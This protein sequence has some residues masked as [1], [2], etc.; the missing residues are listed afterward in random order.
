MDLELTRVRESPRVS[1][2]SRATGEQVGYFFFRGL[3]ILYPCLLLWSNIYPVRIGGITFQLILAISMVVLATGASF[4]KVLGKMG[5][6]WIVIIAVGTIALA[7]GNTL[8]AE[9]RITLATLNVVL[10]A[11]VM[12]P[13]YGALCLAYL[14]NAKRKQQTNKLVLIVVSVSAIFGIVHFWFFPN[15]VLMNEDLHD[16]LSFEN[17]GLLGYFRESGFMGNP[18]GW[19]AFLLA[20]MIAL[21]Y[22]DLLK[23]R[24]MLGILVAL[25]LAYSIS[26]SASR[27][28]TGFALLLLAIAVRR[29]LGHLIALHSPIEILLIFFIFIVLFGGAA[30]VRIDPFTP[31]FY[32]PSRVVNDE[33]VENRIASSELGVRALLVDPMEFLLGLPLDL[34]NERL[35]D[36]GGLT[37][38]DNSFVLIAIRYG[39]PA[40]LGW[41]IGV[42]AS[43][44]KLKESRRDIIPLC[45]VGAT[46]LLN[47][48]V[49][50]DIWMFFVLAAITSKSPTN[51]V[52]SPKK[53]KRSLS[54]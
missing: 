19:G 48:A 20:G 30:V 6:G 49:L 5:V 54:I 11:F 23:K 47:N 25:L 22:G 17:I 1:D 21:L 28:A 50:W 53:C 3:I 7:L 38:S 37:F 33:L 18:N 32:G 8:S 41:T 46:L 9:N 14:T 29:A 12:F 52:S 43:L 36:V 16:F 42:I 51:I 26:L 2:Y 10:R 24:G 31:S 13:L 39:I 45:Y 35:V 4:S 40:A 27:L 15:F 34:A 44:M